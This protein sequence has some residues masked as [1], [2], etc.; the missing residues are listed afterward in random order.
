I[1][2]GGDIWVVDRGNNR[3]Q[4][5]TAGG[6]FVSKFGALGLGLGQLFAPNGIAIGVDGTVWVSDAGKVQRFT[7]AGEF[8]ERVGAG[9]GPDELTQPQSL[10]VDPAGNVWVA[11]AGND[12]VVV[13]DKNG[14]YIRNF[15]SAGTGPGQF[16]WATEVELDADG[17]AW[18]GD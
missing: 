10:D 4:R 12:R 5:F 11:S 8:I 14:D 2:S 3:V 15:G 17:N 16:S 18:V 9:T 7:A 13:F 1:D 6:Q